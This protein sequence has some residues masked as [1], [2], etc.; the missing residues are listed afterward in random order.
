MWIRK[1]T[2][3]D[4]L[5]AID[6]HFKAAFENRNSKFLNPLRN[7]KSGTTGFYSIRSGCWW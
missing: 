1:F 7:G 3:H 4:L 6:V 2:K 5:F